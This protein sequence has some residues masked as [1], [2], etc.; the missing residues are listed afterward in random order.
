MNYLFLQNIISWILSNFTCPDCKAKP[1]ADS[2]DIK[3]VSDKE[4]N[5]HF[6]CKHCKAKA[7]MKAELGQLAWGFLSTEAGKN[8]LKNAI[9]SNQFMIADA[10]N[11]NQKFFKKNSESISSDEIHQIE[12]KLSKNPTINDLINGD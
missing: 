12:E 5:I 8:F 3:S 7:L 2:L 9:E 10:H 1:N 6:T 4:M 11:S